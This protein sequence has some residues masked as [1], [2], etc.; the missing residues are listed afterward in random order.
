MKNKGLT[1]IL[2]GVLLFTCTACTAPDEVEAPTPTLSSLLMSLPTAVPPEFDPGAA[3]DLALS[4]TYEFEK[5]SIPLGLHRYGYMI[6]CPAITSGV[7]G[8][9]WIS[10]I[11]SENEELLNIPVYLR[12][13]G[14]STDPL[15]GYQVFNLHPDQEIIAVVTFMGISEE[16]VQIVSGSTDCDVIIRLDDVLNFNLVPGEPYKP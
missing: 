8:S 5:E 2:I 12:F 4:F 3:G 6:S 10:F 1:F 11:V 16:T 15:S 7:T 14:M 13:A 9:D